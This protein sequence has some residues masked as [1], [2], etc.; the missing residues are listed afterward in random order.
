MEISPIVLGS[1]KEE[2]YKKK[3]VLVEIAP[4][5]LGSLKEEMYRS[6]KPTNSI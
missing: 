4:I 1:L 3:T 2:T 5:V 6:W